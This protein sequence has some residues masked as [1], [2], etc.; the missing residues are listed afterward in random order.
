VNE[1]S[2]SFMNG[3]ASDPPGLCIVDSRAW[4]AV[5]PGVLAVLFAVLQPAASAGLDLG[6]RLVFW[7]C[8]TYVAVGALLLAS[9]GLGRAGL[10]DRLGPWPAI[11]VSGLL[12]SLLFAPL[13]LPLEGLFEVVDADDPERAAGVAGWVLAVGLEL[14]SLAGPVTV[15]WVLINAPRLLR[16]GFVAPQPA[17]SS[18]PTPDEP[19]VRSADEGRIFFEQLPDALGREVVA[20]SSELH[21]LRVHTTR[22]QAL[23]LHSLRDA[24]AD[25]GPGLQVHRSHWVAQAHV[26]RV[27]RRRDGVVCIMS[28]GLEV[29]VSRRRQREVVERFGDSASY[30]AGG[31]ASGS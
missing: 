25:A 26:R 14:G 4:F 9:L 2:N 6:Y 21:Y 11:V 28:T 19:P 3:P 12:G 8:H 18:G 5:V 15:S 16:L 10:S 20:L 29:P 30:G 22:G 17:A 13:A 31:V 23:I 7:L 1:R 24:M 27:R